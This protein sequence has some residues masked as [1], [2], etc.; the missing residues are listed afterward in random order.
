[1]CSP[2]AAAQDDSYGLPAFSLSA[3]TSHSGRHQAFRTRKGRRLSLTFGALLLVAISGGLVYHY[4]VPAKRLIPDGDAIYIGVVQNETGDPQLDHIVGKA[5][6]MDLQQSTSIRVLV[7]QQYSPPRIAASVEDNNS[8]SDENADSTTTP[9]PAN[10]TAE[11]VLSAASHAGA[12]VYVAGS[13]SR[14]DN[15]ILLQVSVFSVKTGLS[16]LSVSESAPDAAHLF[17]AVDRATTSLRQ[18]FG[19]TQPD[20]ER[21]AVP[22]VQMASA[23]LPAVSVFTDA[24][25]NLGQRRILDAIHGYKSATALDPNFAFAFMRLAE[26]YA[27]LGDDGNAYLNATHAVSLG[28]DL[29]ERENHLL[30]FDKALYSGEWEDAEGEMSALAALS[31]HDTAICYR[32]AMLEII[33]ARYEKALSHAEEAMHTHP[34][35]T[36]VSQFEAEALLGLNRTDAA[37][38]VETSGTGSD[39]APLGLTLQTAYILGNQKIVDAQSRAITDADALDGALDYGVY[40]DNSGQW[41]QSLTQWTAFAQRADKLQL[42][43]VAAGML[44]QAAFDRA[45]ADKCS[46]ALD[47]AHQAEAYKGE[48]RFSQLNG[49]YIAIVYALCGQPDTARS[50]AM[51]MDA[52]FNTSVPVHGIYVPEILAAAELASGHPDAALRH[53][54]SVRQP[55]LISIVPYL[56]GRAH[57]ESGQPSQ[58][59]A[60]LQQIVQNRG[61]YLLNESPVYAPTLALMAASYDKLGDPMNGSDAWQRLLANRSQA[62]KDDPLL[63]DAHT[64]IRN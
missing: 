34:G 11:T 40:L 26:S 51:A 7:G 47:F 52:Q 29:G 37:L 24:E 3:S 41:K 43:G 12:Q 49:F 46:G 16:I 59:I 35:T 5:L 64:H 38:N 56:S 2:E 48:A 62:D 8:A 13:L 58:A 33:E 1:V 4:L 57:L 54:D 28:V 20:I 30:N 19:E 10:P 39:A 23:S 63:T 42:P 32:R 53:L 55:A 21:T 15:E 44:A 25:A 60:D 6:A 18:R 9:P 31:P 17:D 36:F 50:L 45:L 22:F 14:S 61:A 27:A